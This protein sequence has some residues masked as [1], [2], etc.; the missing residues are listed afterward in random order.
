MTFK[1]INIVMIL[2]MGLSAVIQFNDPDPIRWALLYAAATV[3]AIMHW[4]NPLHAGSTVAPIIVGL[5]AIGWGLLLLPNV[6]ERP[7]S[8]RIFESMDPD[9][10][11]IEE[12]RE[13]IGLLMVGVWMG[14]LSWRSRKSSP[15]G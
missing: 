4:R 7:P 5:I 15:A 3:L 12:A 2:F 13:F 8:M 11:E 10:P 1:T 9:F 6:L 14:V